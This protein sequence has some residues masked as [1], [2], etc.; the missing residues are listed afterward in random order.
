MTLQIA[1]SF[2]SCWS[3]P[4]ESGRQLDDTSC[5]EAMVSYLA[6]NGLHALQNKVR[7]VDRV[8]VVLLELVQ[9]GSQ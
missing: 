6:S 4:H 9:V 7:G 8:S 5:K 3:P 1:F 2:V